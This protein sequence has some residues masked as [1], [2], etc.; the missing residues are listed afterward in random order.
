[1]R[2][3]DMDERRCGFVHLYGVTQMVILLAKKRGLNVE[4]CAT[5]AMLHDIWSYETKDFEDHAPKSAVEARRILTN[6]ERYSEDEIG[7]I[8]E[9]I[10]LHSDKD[11]THGAMAETLKD[12]DAVQHCLYNPALGRGHQGRVARVFMELGISV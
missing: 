10:A 4:L 3:E 12:A 2:Q 6:L 1:M 8:C 5:A 7:T 9:A 11:A